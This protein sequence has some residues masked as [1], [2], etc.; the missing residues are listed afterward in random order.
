MG[1]FFIIENLL[2]GRCDQFKTPREELRGSVEII[3]TDDFRGHADK[4]LANGNGVD[5]RKTSSQDITVA[6]LFV[7]SFFAF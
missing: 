7:N 2:G 6:V 3:G 1:Y 4:N 5:S